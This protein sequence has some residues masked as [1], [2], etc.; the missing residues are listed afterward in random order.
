VE[1]PLV[2]G[3]Y[4]RLHGAE[5]GRQALSAAHRLEE[6]RQPLGQH[7]EHAQL[8]CVEHV[9]RHDVV[10]VTAPR[11]QAVHRTENGDKG[12]SAVRVANRLAQA[13]SRVIPTDNRGRQ[14]RLQH[15]HNG[16]RFFE[17]LGLTAADQ[18]AD[19]AMRAIVVALVAHKAKKVALFNLVYDQPDNARD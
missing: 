14:L 4:R 3:V 18:A 6:G 17:G 19:H 7:M 1:T 8:P 2:D 15:L 5:S 11:A 16:S 13:R 10:H 9:E 12:E